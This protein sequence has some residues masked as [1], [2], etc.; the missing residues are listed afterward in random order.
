ML[1][2]FVLTSYLYGYSNELYAAELMMPAVMAASIVRMMFFPVFMGCLVQG[3]VF[4]TVLFGFVRLMMIGT[5]NPAVRMMTAVRKGYGSCSSE[6][7]SHRQNS[8]CNFT[9]QLIF[10]NQV[11]PIIESPCYIA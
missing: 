7:Q 10:H 5:I 3:T 2:V 6:H 9:S 8:C 4:G 11:P 1:S